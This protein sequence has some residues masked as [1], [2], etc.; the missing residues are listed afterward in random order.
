M[1]SDRKLLATAALAA[2]V[3]GAPTAYAADKINYLLNW[4]PGGDHAP[5]FFAQESGWYR[6]AGLDVTI[7][8]GKGSA[9][10]A[11]R[12]GLGTTQLALSDLATAL[13]AK[14]KGAD[15]TAVMVVYANA[16]Y[17]IYWQKSSGIAGPK[18]FPGKK[19]G[20]PPGDAARVLWPAFAKAVGIPVDSV[21]FV[22]ISPQ[23]KL[24][25]LQSGSI[26]LTTDFYNGHDVKIREMGDNMGYLLWKDA[27]INT[28]GNSILVNG[29]YL[30]NNREAVGKFV[31][32]T[33]RAFAACVKDEA[34]CIDALLK[35]ASGLKGQEHL[36][37]WRRVKELMTDATT[38]TV[39]LGAFD[40]ARVAA[41]YKLVETYFGIDKPFDAS[42]AFTNEFLDKSIKM[43]KEG[44]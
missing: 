8:T 39:A 14:G 6:N 41:D 5:Y 31:G 34:P 10:S 40:P 15:L 12:V 38:T 44:S 25:A 16:P 9:I 37:Q 28:Y 17:G 22:N 1:T 2:F 4:V 43:P 13:V 20:N 27:G 26:D 19:L 32:V 42:S 35:N 23:A 11:Q 24:A 7:E 29:E 21:T 33:Q 18:D 30:R 3:T 36:D